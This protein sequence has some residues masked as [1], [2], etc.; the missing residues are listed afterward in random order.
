MRSSGTARLTGAVAALAGTGLL[1]VCLGGSTS[2]Q[3]A[4]SSGLAALPA[5]QILSR[6]TA[7]ATAAGSLHF[8]STTRAGS[9]SIIFNEDSAVSGGRQ[10]ITISSGG[11]M[12]VLL[13]HGV[14]YVNGN[15]AGLSGFLGLPAETAV[16]LAG[17]WIS[18]ARGNPTYPLVAT[19]VTT[20]SVLSE[21][22]PVGPLTKTAPMT[23]DGQTAVGVSGP[24]PASA[25]MPKGSRTTVYV[26]ASGKPLPI[27]CRQGPGGS[28]TRIALTHWGEHVSLAPPHQAVPVPSPSPAQPIPD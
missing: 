15:A 7:A 23:V 16:A 25:G 13:I 27:S 5:S 10:R 8:H 28:Q 2:Q 21:I 19:G 4:A 1:A 9:S 6:A 14:G 24:A 18:V 20:R 11:T 26:A 22:S 3:P 17:H 12:T